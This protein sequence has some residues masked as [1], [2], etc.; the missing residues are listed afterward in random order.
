[1][2]Y[3]ERVRRKGS[4]PRR[5][6]YKLFYRLFRR[7][8]Y[9]DIPVDAGD[10]GLIDRAALDVINAMP[11]RDRF[12]RGLRAWAGLQPSRRALCPPGAPR[13]AHHQ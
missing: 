4:L 7:L 6:G 1:M 3:G 12:I 2:V 11:E 13:R 8:S 5:I 9:I 10:F